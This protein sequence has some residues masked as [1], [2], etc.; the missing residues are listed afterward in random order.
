MS[1]PRRILCFGNPLH[2]DDGFGPAVAAHLR[3]LPLP[4][5]IQ[6]VDCGVRGLDALALF[7]GCDEILVVDAAQGPDAGR[8]HEL[9]ADDVMPETPVTG[10]AGGLG[11]LLQYMRCLPAPHPLVRIMAV[12]TPHVAAFQPV[13]SSPVRQAI[14]EIAGRI[15]RHWG[16]DI[17]CR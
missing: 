4:D 16:L 15:T 17:Q 10:H 7:E 13:L 11:Q 2:G 3:T 12:E 1:S 9:S 5:D 14:P 6:V 8:I